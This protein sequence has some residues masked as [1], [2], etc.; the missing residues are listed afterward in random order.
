MNLTASVPQLPPFLVDNLILLSILNSTPLEK[1]T[2]FSITILV[3]L[4]LPNFY[5]LDVLELNIVQTYFVFLLALVQFVEE[6]EWVLL[7][8]VMELET[9]STEQE[10]EWVPIFVDE[11]IFV[12]EPELVFVQVVSQPEFIPISPTEQKISDVNSDIDKQHFEHFEEIPP[13]EL[14]K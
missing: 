8:I 13:D 7:Q 12:V 5:L 9:D 14:I 6:A 4:V 1:I 2:P 11:L 10:V 3:D